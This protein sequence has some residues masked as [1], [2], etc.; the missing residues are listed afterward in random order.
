MI[1]SD[2]PSQEGSSTRRPV[3]LLGGVRGGLV[4]DRFMKRENLRA[5]KGVRAIGEFWIDRPRLPFV[6]AMPP[7]G[8]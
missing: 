7:F 1:T 2:N 3:P 8:F 6:S 4:G 5:Y